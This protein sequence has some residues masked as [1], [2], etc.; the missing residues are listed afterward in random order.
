MAPLTQDQEA[1]RP[2]AHEG[3]ILDT[4]SACPPLTPEEEQ[5]YA[6]LID[7]AKR[8]KRP[9]VEAA[10]ETAAAAIASLRN[11]TIEQARAVVAASTQGELWSWDVLHFDDEAIGEIA[12]AEVLADPARFHGATLADPLEG[13]SYGRSKAKL[14]WNADNAVVINSFAHGGCVYAVHHDADYIEAQVEGAGVRAPDVLAALMV[15]ARDFGAITCERLR[16]LAAKVG[17]AGKL[18]VKAAIK[19]AAQKARRSAAAAARARGD[20]GK[21]ARETFILRGGERP[22]QLRTIEAKLRVAANVGP[23][24]VIARGQAAAVIRCRGRPRQAAGRQAR[25]QAA[26]RQRLPRRSAS[27]APAGAARPPVRLR[28]SGRQRRTVRGRLSAGS[29]PVHP[30]QRESAAAPVHQPHPRAAPGRQR[31]GPARVRC[32]DR[33]LLRA[34]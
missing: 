6:E 3:D 4:A 2:I 33:H 30:R 12:V 32:R 1:R 34:G 23:G 15:H 29:G 18:A 5:R 8:E 27:R 28:E 9:E 25:D 21:P 17:R 24:A 22:A 13:R 31:P 20:R 19:D 10:K 26:G 11:I 7:A 14:Y 16:N